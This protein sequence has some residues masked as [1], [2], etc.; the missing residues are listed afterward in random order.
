MKYINSTKGS[1]FFLFLATALVF[2]LPEMST[3]FDSDIILTVSTFL[4]AILVGFDLSRLY[5]R[6][7]NVRQNIAEEDARLL[8]FYAKAEI[9][10]KGFSDRIKKIIDKYC[11][12]FLDYGI[13][14]A[15]GYYY[16]PTSKHFLQL[17]R[18]MKK[19]KKHRHEG[20][21]ESML[22]D[23]SYLE[24]ARNKA[25]VFIYAQ[26]SLRKQYFLFFLALIILLILFID[27]RSLDFYSKIITIL[28]SSS[29][30]LILLL[31]RDLNN[32]MVQNKGIG[33]ESKEEVLEFM[34][35]GRYYNKLNKD[36]GYIFIPKNLE[37]YRLGLHKPG[38]KQDIKIIK[39]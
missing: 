25:S 27:V 9:Y 3:N 4:F 39:H 8:S 21:Y 23:L 19:I 20:T 33:V 31:L 26:M 1:L 29:L 14:K 12:D 37:N 13:W 28:L 24:T 2:I 5:S 34:G 11:I 18:E 22:D 16:K 6:Y 38:D 15:E 30:V 17:Y 36:R 35:L 32:F 10:G 7:T